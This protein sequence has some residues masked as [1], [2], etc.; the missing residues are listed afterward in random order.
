MRVYRKIAIFSFGVLSSCTLS[1]SQEEQVEKILPTP[2]MEVSAGE[3]LNSP[4]FEEGK[5]PSK[6]WWTQYGSEELNQLI[7]KAIA[8]NPTIQAAR[9]RIAFAKNKAVIARSE[10]FPLIY[11]DGSDKWQ[12]L[13]KNGLYRAFNPN[14]KLNSN[15]IDF[16]LS[17]SYE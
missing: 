13:S 17:F 16:S 11:F 12:Y 7:E 8:F 5:W 9:E 6:T 10:L 14:L 4:F 2:S 3:A 1:L 15:V